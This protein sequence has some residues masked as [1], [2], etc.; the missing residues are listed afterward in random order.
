VTCHQPSETR[1]S[2]KAGILI[3]LA[4]SPFVLWM[5]F[6]V[7]HAWLGWQG[8]IGESVPYG[9]VTFVY[10]LWGHEA[11]AGGPIVGIDTQ[12]VY[13][14]LALIPIMVGAVGEF[15]S[16]QS[17]PYA[18]ILLVVLMDAVAFSFL[19]GTWARIRIRVRR[20]NMKGATLASVRV[21]AAWWWLLFLVCLGPIAVARIDSLASPLAMMG[22]VFAISRPAVSSSLLTLAAWIKVWPAAI[23]ATLW[24]S[25]VKRAT[26]VISALV[27]SAVIAGI[28]LVLG[29]GGNVFS[30]LTQQ[31][32]R[33]LQIE[34]PASTLF[35]WLSAARVPGFS[36]YYEKSLLTFQV[37]GAGTTVV[38]QL[39]TV[40][41]ILI[42]VLILILGLDARRH[43]AVVLRL[44]GPLALAM[45]VALIAFNKVGSPQYIGWLAVP[46]VYG[47]VIDR[48]RFRVP[49]IL[50]LVIALLTQAFY[51]YLYL[52][53]L[54]LN[55]WLVAVLSLRNI[56]EFVL[57]GYAI[58]MLVRVRNDARRRDARHLR[59]RQSAA[60][61]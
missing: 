24:I 26:V 39:S 49:A 48:R 60:I 41:L 43:G 15:A 31:T 12:W 52:E 22:L 45:T 38:A 3:A 27:T 17:Y 6:I 40:V 19:I 1:D 46:L 20:G 53:L 44:L 59:D 57:L 14:I 2:P 36:V 9:D 23:V 35:V 37:Q 32:G 55:P 34:S 5:A 47:L 33:G 8:Y 10:W 58:A 4:R 18:W 56:L 29:A 21:T 7:V 50:A 28:A 25:G 16:Q 13:P 42:A 61:R 51:P 54:N 30:F 11:A